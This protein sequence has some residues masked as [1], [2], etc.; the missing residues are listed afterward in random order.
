MVGKPYVLALL[1]RFLWH[2]G[3]PVSDTAFITTYLVSE[4]ARRD[5]TVILSGVGGD[6][7]FGGYRR[8]LGNHYQAYFERLPAWARRAASAVGHRPPSDRHPPL[9]HLS[10]LA[11]G[12]LLNAG[13]PV[14]R[15]RLTDVAGMLPRDILERKKRGFGTPMGAWLKQDL[16]PLVRELLSERVVDRRGLFRYPAVRDLIAA[17]EAN[18]LDGTDRLLALINLEI[19]SRMY[20]DRRTPEDV[21]AE[22]KGMLA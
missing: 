18:R 22:L 13:P 21:T 14:G 11:Q 1:P 15:R 16:A 7:L 5:V 3:E 20:L 17:H 19:W 12:V 2:R 8:Y 9:L 6:E 4:F 10:P